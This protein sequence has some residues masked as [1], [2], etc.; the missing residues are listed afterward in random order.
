MNAQRFVSEA[1]YLEL[2]ERSPL[3]HEYLNG[4]VFAMAGGGNAHALLC[5]QGV[6]SLINALRGKPCRAVGSEQRVKV[7]ETGERFYPDAAVYCPGARLEGREGQEL[8][9]P[10]VIIEVMSP[11]SER[12]DRGDKFDTYKNIASLTDYILVERNRVRVE[13]FR[14][15]NDD[16]LVR[17]YVSRAD[18]IALS[19]V[20]GALS[21]SELYEGLNVPEGVMSEEELAR[22]ELQDRAQT[23]D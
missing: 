7:E 16:W 8:L 9:D 12:F 21:L 14:R 3:K 15:V 20:D 4:E 18:V 6:S 2:E 5:A 1:E 19:S 11:S 22:L 23:D 17:S 10:K 13:H